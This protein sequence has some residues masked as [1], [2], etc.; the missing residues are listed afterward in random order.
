MDLSRP[1]AP[2][3]FELRFVV[4]AAAVDRNGH[5]N[6]VEYVRWMQDVA[7]QH[8]EA[9]GG[10]AAIESLGMSWVARSHLIE[11]LSPAFAGDLVVAW[12]WVAQFR[13]VRS[14]RRYLFTRAAD[15]RVLA[16][17]AT[18]WVCVDARTGRPR[19]IPSQ[20]TRLFLLV[21]DAPP[22]PA[23]GA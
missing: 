11:Y 10:T 14:T 5:A 19:T 18:E 1:P 17:G 23:P 12:T 2:G 7:V 9:T 15:A 21:P 22:L 6:N 16:R 4:P 13:R 8:A 3:V 20:V